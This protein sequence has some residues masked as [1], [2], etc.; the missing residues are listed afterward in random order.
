MH[1]EFIYIIQLTQITDFTKEIIFRH[2][3]FLSSLDSEGKLIL[4]GP[5]LDGEGGM[6][7]I[8]A[9]D[10]KEAEEIAGRDPFVLKGFSKCKVFTMKP[11]NKENNYLL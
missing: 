5:I 11:A 9:K 8:N 10:K 1:S 7:I 4:G 6:I 2:V 3:E